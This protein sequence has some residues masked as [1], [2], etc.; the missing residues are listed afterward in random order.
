MRT[1][2]ILLDVSFLLTWMSNTYHNPVTPYEVLCELSFIISKQST[3]KE[4]SVR[5]ISVWS[6]YLPHGKFKHL[7]AVI[8]NTQRGRIEVPTLPQIKHCGGK[9]SSP[10]DLN[11]FSQLSQGSRKG[12]LNFSKH[13]LEVNGVTFTSP[14]RSPAHPWGAETYKLKA[15]GTPLKW[16]SH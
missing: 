14:R 9:Q 15:Q 2:I 4:V 11:F 5:L 6:T 1:H 3:F 8:P 12:F 10:K 16:R 13:F 7:E